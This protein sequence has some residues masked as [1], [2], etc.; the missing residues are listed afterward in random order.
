[1]A[2]FAKGRSWTAA[3]VLAVGMMAGTGLVEAAQC[4]NNGAGYNAWLQQTIKEA[5]GRGIG[6]RAISAL[7]N[8]KYAQATINADRNQ[9]SFKLSFEQFMQKRGANTIIQ[10]GRSMKKQNAALFAAIEKRYVVPAG[11]LLAI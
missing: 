3:A 10:R 5:Q 9:K 7:T 11:P 1:M 6:K 2:L 4:G 8:T